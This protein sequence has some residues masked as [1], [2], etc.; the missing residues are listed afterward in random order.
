MSAGSVDAGSPVRGLRPAS[1]G[2]W[3]LALALFV[4]VTTASAQPADPA[5]LQFDQVFSAKGEPS[6]M[7]FRARFASRGEQHVLEVWRDGDRRLTRRTDDA[8]EI[9]VAREPGDPDYQMVVLDLRH[10]IETR[11]A[12]DDLYRL[13]SF[14]DWFDLAHGLRHPKASYRLTSI[15]EPGGAPRPLRTCKWFALEQ[16]GR[17]VR[18][19]WSAQEH[20]PLL[21]LGGHDEV[22]WQVTEVEHKLVAA[23]VFEIHDVGFVRNDAHRDITGD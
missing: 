3:S 20:L 2:S 22:L 13:G 4:S 9:H 17:N 16:Q 11:I 18:V 6:A 1:V 8:S 7:H 15:V 10:K 23:S 14:T 19:C 12:R 21:V 5:G